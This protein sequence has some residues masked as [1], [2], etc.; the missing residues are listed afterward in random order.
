MLS[1]T[2]RCVP[3]FTQAT[4]RRKARHATLEAAGVAQV[5]EAPQTIH[6][7]HPLPIEGGQF[8]GPDPL[9]SGEAPAEE[10]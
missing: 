9:T 10:E 1:E 6:D 7:R 4:L 5:E 8:Y 2:N 3:F